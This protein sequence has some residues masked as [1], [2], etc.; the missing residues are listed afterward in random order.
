MWR[1][2]VRWH[3]GSWLV[4]SFGRGEE[5][6]A[7]LSNFPLDCVSLRSASVRAKRMSLAYSTVGQRC[8]R[9]VRLSEA[10]VS[11]PSSAL[12]MKNYAR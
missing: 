3:S 9:R 11:P 6:V 1:L 12:P 5:S 7:S 8:R 4:K 10:K 2:P